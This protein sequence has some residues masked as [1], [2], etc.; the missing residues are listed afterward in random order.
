M[1]FLSMNRFSSHS[2]ENSME[3]AQETARKRRDFLELAIGYG[4]ILLA[5]WTNNPLQRW[6]YG[7][8]LLWVLLVTGISFDGWKAMG[9][10][11]SG[12][13]RSLW[14][15]GIAL[16]A[17]AAAMELARRFHTLNEPH[18]FVALIARFWGY[19]LWALAQQFLLQ[20]F[21]LLRLLRLLPSRRAAV[22]V[23]TGLF[24]IAHLPNPLLIAATVIWGLAAC[25]LFLRYRNLYSLAMAHAIFGICI[26][27]TIPGQVDHNMRVGRG[28][29][30][31]RRPKHHL[32]HRD[33]TVSTAACVIADAPTRRS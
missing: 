33:H 13:W 18:G 14:V 3:A 7:A 32:N 22:L 16:L 24:V 17:A 25:L 1:A 15:V 11:L 6:F 4:L 19:S 30:N 10:H 28:Y 9:F 21:V 29:S 26:A 12:L 27:I 5:I 31:Y 20:D 23:A 2:T 8:S